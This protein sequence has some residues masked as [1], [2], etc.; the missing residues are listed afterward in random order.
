LAGVSS[1]LSPKPR[2]VQQELNRVLEDYKLFLL[3]AAGFCHYAANTKAL[4]AVQENGS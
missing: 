3:P 1:E 2:K 4:L